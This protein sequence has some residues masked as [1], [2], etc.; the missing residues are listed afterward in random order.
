MTLTLL[1]IRA[2]ARILDELDYYQ[3]LEIEPGASSDEIKKAYYKSS[4]LFHPDAN[5]GIEEAL[6]LDCERISKRVT[7]AYCVLRDPRRRKVYD[8]RDGTGTRMQLATAKAEHKRAQAEERQGKTP[9]GRQY[10]Q[11]AQQ[12]LEQGNARTAIQNLQ[13]ALTFEPGNEGFKAQIAELRAEN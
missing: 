4:R 5:R 1:E 6:K 3:I 12:D 2:L 7:E 11:K 13:M 8:G 10:F 9:Q